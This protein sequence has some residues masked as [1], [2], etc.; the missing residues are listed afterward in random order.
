M[1]LKG[2]V[3]AGVE[4]DLTVTRL[5]EDRFYLVTSCAALEHVMHW[6]ESSLCDKDVR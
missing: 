5:A 2:E 1:K 4:A 3:E 6:L